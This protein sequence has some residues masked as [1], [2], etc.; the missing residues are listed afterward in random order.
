MGQT[1]PV[2]VYFRPFHNAITNIAQNL[3]IND[4]SIYGVPG[5]QTLGS[6]MEGIDESTEL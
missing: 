2:F 6:I 4:K 5:T 3:T 1:R